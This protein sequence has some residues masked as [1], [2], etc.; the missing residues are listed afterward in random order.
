[1]EREVKTN[2]KSQSDVR[3]LANTMKFDSSSPVK[4]ASQPSGADKDVKAKATTDLPEEKTP[5]IFVL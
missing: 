2:R 5:A 1:M 3:R 4:K